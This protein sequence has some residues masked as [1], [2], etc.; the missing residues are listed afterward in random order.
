MLLVWTHIKVSV[1]IFFNFFQDFD[2]FFHLIKLHLIL[3]F[4]LLN[5]FCLNFNITC[6][7]PCAPPSGWWIITSLFGNANLPFVLASKNAPIAARPMQIVDITFYIMYC[8]INCKP[9]AHIPPGLLY[10]DK[11]LC[12]GVFSF[13]IN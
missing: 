6:L 1:C 7:D 9:C 3:F 5:V 11:Y 8:V 10:K 2:L 4:Y 12:L 13:K